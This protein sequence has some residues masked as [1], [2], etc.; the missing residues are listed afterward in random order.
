MPEKISKYLRKTDIILILVLAFI[1]CVMMVFNLIPHDESR[2]RLEISKDGNILG[3]YS[4]AEDRVI[5]IGDGNTCRIEGGEVFMSYADCPDQ[6]CVNSAHIDAHGG[7]IVCLPNKVILKIVSAE[8]A[9]DRPDV[10]AS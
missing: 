7:S 2:A 5:E 10:I 3:T 1:P 9:A 8:S 4:L 6:I